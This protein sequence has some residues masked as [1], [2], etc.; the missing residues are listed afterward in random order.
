MKFARL[1]SLSIVFAFLAGF[2]SPDANAQSDEQIEPTQIYSDVDFVAAVQILKLKEHLNDEQK[3]DF[4]FL[5]EWVTDFTAL[6][7]GD[8]TEILCQFGAEDYES[9]PGDSVGF[10]F[11]RDAAFDESAIGGFVDQFS[12]DSE[13]VEG[14]SIYYLRSEPGFYFKENSF[15]IA[16]RKRI[17]TLIANE[18]EDPNREVPFLES[19]SKSADVSVHVSFDN[20]SFNDFFVELFDDMG[21]FRRPGGPEVESDG[22]QQLIA[23]TSTATL[24]LVLDSEPNLELRLAISDKDSMDRAKEE[25]QAFVDLAVDWIEMITEE[26]EFAPTSF[27]ESMG[28]FLTICKELFESAEVSVE[29]SQ[30]VVTAKHPNVTKLPGRFTESMRSLVENFR[31]F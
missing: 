11:R 15:L 21:W 12:M 10:V 1:F 3:E 7:T 8:C 20:E 19:V 25:T 28:E 6:P 14:E 13:E 30:V 24:N 31:D 29:G 16:E 23:M 5:M 22:F 17:A 2:I 18:K 4:N 9:N 26:L 27:Q